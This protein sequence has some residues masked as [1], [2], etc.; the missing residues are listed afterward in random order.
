MTAFIMAA[1]LILG[2]SILVLVHEFGHFITARIFGIRVN[3]FY[4][5]FN[6]KISL[7]KCK[8]ID[9]KLRWKFFSKNLPD[10]ELVVDE[11]GKPVLDAKGKK[12][13]KSIDVSTLNDSDW[14]K[15]PEH[16]EYG[17]GW[18]PL[19]GYCQIAGMIDET[20][21][22]DNLASEPQPWEFRSKPAWQRLIVVSGGVIINLVVGVL[23]FALILGAYEKQYLP[24]Q[25]VVDGIYAYEPA[26][27]LGFQS[28]DKIVNID[29]KP[30]E[31]FQD[32]SSAKIFFGAIVT[33]ER[34]GKLMDIVIAENAYNLLKSG[35]EFFN[36]TNFPFKIDTLLAGMPAVNAGI[37]KGDKIIAINDSINIHS[38]GSFSENIRRFPNQDVILTVLRNNDTLKKTV[39]LD[40]TSL[41]GIS[42][43]TYPY[44]L[45]SYSFG[46][47]LSYGWKDAMT[48][49]SLN[50]KGLK[51]VVS[52]EEKAK[53]SVSGPIGIAQIYG[54]EW[55]WA[56]FWYI[57]G[58]LSL[59]LAFMNILPIPGLDGGFV[60]F[61]LIEMIIGRKLP[62]KFMEY[63]LT[64]G[65]LL[66]MLLMIFVF[67]NDIFKLFQ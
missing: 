37:L 19:G 47:A 44:T 57:T 51:K 2:L 11:A 23:L 8:K 61:T 21:S 43:T 58:L 41:I 10:M 17:M 55:I 16:T 64:V 6:P 36:A 20:Q 62:D 1:Q 50:I 22:I 14:R 67:G 18:L 52:G 32:A 24:N 4:I 60:L 38:W 56:K 54:G 53:D 5:F 46:Q 34:E 65:W 42:M 35:K 12:Q 40:S 33:V 59:I 25:A 13:Y 30:V 66:L 49:L 27:T 9:G 31:R 3:K 63:A 26:R 48:M 45:K 28:G 39:S 7:I 29:G 15:H